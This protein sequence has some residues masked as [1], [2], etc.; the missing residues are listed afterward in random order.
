MGTLI[1]RHR[2]KDYDKWRQVFD[3]HK[4]AQKAAGLSNPRVFRSSD[5]RN[6]VVILFDT[7]DTSRA[8]DF[9]GSADLKETMSKAGV[10]DRPTVYFL[11]SA[12]PLRAMGT[13]WIELLGLHA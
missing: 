11:D 9:T 1:I 8:K 7:A 6:E 3:R 2:V 13:G 12:Q 10:L 5:D 4:R